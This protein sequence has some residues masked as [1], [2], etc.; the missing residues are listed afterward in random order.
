MTPEEFLSG[1]QIDSIYSFKY[2][3]NGDVDA[4]LLGKAIDSNDSGILYGI[5]KKWDWFNADDVKKIVTN[6]SG[7]NDVIMEHHVTLPTNSESEFT[8]YKGTYPNESGSFFDPPFTAYQGN[9]LLYDHVDNAIPMTKSK[10]IIHLSWMDMTNIKIGDVYEMVCLDVGNNKIL[11]ASNAV[12]DYIF[13]YKKEDFIVL[14]MD[15]GDLF[16][17]GIL[18]S[19]SISLLPIYRTVVDVRKIKSGE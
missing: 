13:K 2:N 12:C 18:L 5:S 15:Y 11:S 19:Y 8:F 6:K 14:E 7:I 10:L 1:L 3:D 17:D 9:S 16:K 4:T